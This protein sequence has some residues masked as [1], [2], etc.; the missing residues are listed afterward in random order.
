MGNTYK[1]VNPPIA[2]LSFPLDPWADNIIYL[3]GEGI[4]VISW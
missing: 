2:I 3:A 4:R 1:K